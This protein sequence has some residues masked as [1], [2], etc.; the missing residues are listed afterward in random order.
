M[1]TKSEKVQPLKRVEKSKAE[2]RL[3]RRKEMAGLN[4]A[5]VIICNVVE[6]YAV[7]DLAMYLDQGIKRLRNRLMVSIDSK[8]GVELLE[9][10]TE[11]ICLLDDC[12]REISQTTGVTWY[13]MPRAVKQLREQ[14]GLSVAQ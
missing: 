3:T 13:E 14:L 8:T 5:R 7:V 2:I 12:V 11:A 9:K 10:A 6:T 4:N 1:S